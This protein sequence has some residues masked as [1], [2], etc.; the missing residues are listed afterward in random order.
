MARPLA[1]LIIELILQIFPQILRKGDILIMLVHG[2]S[3][4]VCCQVSSGRNT[5][6]DTNIY[7]QLLF[8]E[9]ARASSVRIVDG[10]FSRLFLELG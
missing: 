1:Y 7:S 5:V 9:M 2:N 6:M 8:V 3:K 10:V 4:N